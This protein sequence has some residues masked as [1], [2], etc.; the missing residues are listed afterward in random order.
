MRY[1]A[2][3]LGDTEDTRGTT[4][5]DHL[6]QNRPNTEVPAWVRSAFATALQYKPTNKKTLFKNNRLALGRTLTKTD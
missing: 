1:D 5:S 3:W 2:V 4:K 6:V